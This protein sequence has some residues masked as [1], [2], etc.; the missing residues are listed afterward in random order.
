MPCK[1]ICI[2]FRKGVK[3]ISYVKL[4][5]NITGENNGRI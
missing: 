5:Y 2:F 1:N 4:K 3:Y